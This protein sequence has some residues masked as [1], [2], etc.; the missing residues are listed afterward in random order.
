[1]A[2]PELAR[3]HAEDGRVRLLVSMF[4]GE[5]ACHYRSLWQLTTPSLAVEYVVA[6]IAPETE[7]QISLDIE[8]LPGAIADVL[9]TDGVAS[10]SLVRDARP[11]VDDSIWYLQTGIP[12]LIPFDKN[13]DTTAKL[14][15]KDLFGVGETVGIYDFSFWAEEC[16]FRYGLLADDVTDFNSTRRLG[17]PY[18]PPYDGP[19]CLFPLPPEHSDPLFLY[20]PC[21]PDDPLI[22]PMPESRA[23]RPLNKVVTVYG[24]G[25]HCSPAI[26]HGTAVTGIAAGDNYEYPLA[27]D[28]DPGV[29][30][31]STNT[32]GI[33]IDHHQSGDGVAPGA[34]IV[35]QNWLEDLPTCSSNRPGGEYFRRVLL[36]AYGAPETRDVG[37]SAIP[38][39]E[40]R[41]H[42]NS[43]S[44]GATEVYEDLPRAAD[45]STWS[46]RDLTVAAAAMNNGHP[47][48]FGP[49]GQKNLA[50]LAH[51]K[52]G[53]AVGATNEATN[54]WGEG[55]GADVACY[56]SH[57][58]GAGPR[59]KPDLV[60]PG[61]TPWD[62][63]NGDYTFPAL[64]L[65]TPGRNATTLC[66]TQTPGLGTSFA[67]PAI[68]G[69]SLLVREYFRR[70]YYPSGAESATDGFIPTNALV[71]AMLVNSTRN[72]KG[73]NTA[74]EGPVKTPRPTY[75]QGWGR[76]VLDDSL[77]FA[78]DPT[79]APDER[80]RLIVLNDVPNGMTEI[81][82][83]NDG[84]V[85]SRVLASFHPAIENG[86]VH[87]YTIDVPNPTEPLHITLN[88]SDPP[89]CTSTCNPLVN[90]LDLE[91]IDPNGKVWRSN[92]VVAPVS[93][94]PG[95]FTVTCSTEKVWTGGF[96]TLSTIGSDST[97]PQNDG[98]PF[99]DF[100]ARDCRNTTENLFINASPGGLV[101]G[102]YLVKVIGYNIDTTSLHELKAQPNWNDHDTDIDADTIN[103]N[104][105]GYAL[106]VSGNVTA[107]V[108]VGAPIVR[109]GCDL[110][111]SPDG[112]LDIS[113]LVNLHVPLTVSVA[114]DNMTAC[115]EAVGHSAL[116]VDI[117]NFAPDYPPGSTPTKCAVYGDMAASSTAM[118]RFPIRLKSSHPLPP[119]VT[120]ALFRL[121]LEADGEFLG[122]YQ[123]NV[124]IDPTPEVLSANPTPTQAGINDCGAF[125]RD[126]EITHIDFDGDTVLDDL[127][128]EF[129]PGVLPAGPSYNIY[130]GDIG[131]AYNDHIAASPAWCTR[132]CGDGSWRGSTDDRC[133]VILHGE[134]FNSLSH[135][136]LISGEAECQ[137]AGQGAEGIL[138]FFFTGMEV[139]FGGGACP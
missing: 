127:L 75:G 59:L 106:V 139:N 109:D 36:Q 78:G 94:P 29:S 111:E 35:F 124:P 116:L 26:N 118:A 85:R 39:T 126:P 134:A 119:T 84:G 56:S 53:I 54:D 101:A 30:E 47:D 21:D 50:D 31:S 103:S 98:P 37:P 7:A 32:F 90:D 136:Y 107:P 86:E 83:M 48:P 104:S 19:P 14:F 9:G 113:E 62:D 52:N 93:G 74:D 16:F 24:S 15:S 63:P 105:Q 122:E 4:R 133:E 80:S 97:T 64:E 46:L 34:Q 138:G 102:T 130:A 81:Y 69:M 60:A 73:W 28:D 25:K 40:V 27:R 17:P 18:G 115:L 70:G 44:Y 42:N 1:M 108:V 128:I 23:C 114:M 12:D 68:T 20:D 61:G 137:D 22:W 5:N 135:Y 99:L 41:A 33:N 67:T 100:A 13:Y 91:V 43:W 72:V 89:S 45:K 77:Y 71:K 123:I 57:G 96:S 58:P 121:E 65:T 92:S 10:V 3:D 76:P 51:F 87:R 8:D 88:W 120:D 129:C 117:G 66:A 82:D 112:Q 11:A 55:P 49:C 131:G 2:N 95:C 38:W 110:T 132:P 6:D 79:N 125:G